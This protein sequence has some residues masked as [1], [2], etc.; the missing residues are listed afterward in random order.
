MVGPEQPAW[1]DKIERGRKIVIQESAIGNT[2][3][4]DAEGDTKTKGAEGGGESV[5]YGKV[6]L[7]NLEPDQLTR[8]VTYLRVR[9]L[10][11]AHL[12]Q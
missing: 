7:V 9:F 5:R 8:T 1:G 4:T 12:V 3:D 6:I 11:S 10:G 2:E